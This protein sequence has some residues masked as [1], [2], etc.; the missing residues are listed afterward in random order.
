MDAEKIL[1]ARREKAEENVLDFF[2]EK[3]R[4]WENEEW[5]RFNALPTV[6]YEGLRVKVAGDGTVAR[7]PSG[8]FS[9]MAVLSRGNLIGPERSPDGTWRFPRL[10]GGVPDDLVQ[11]LFRAR[12]DLRRYWEESG[13]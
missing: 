10:G 12:K 6:N 9:G 3:R 13:N 5:E 1:E 2:R 7:H 11:K 8:M 4:K